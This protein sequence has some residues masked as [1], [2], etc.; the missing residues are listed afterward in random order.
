MRVG[1]EMFA[2]NPCRRWGDTPDNKKNRPDAGYC[3]W[4]NDVMSVLTKSAIRVSGSVR[5]KMHQLDGGT[6]NEQECEEGGEQNTSRGTR[7]PYSLAQDHNY[8]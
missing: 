6:E 2:I 5:V 1:E 3:R 8:S 4:P 7:R